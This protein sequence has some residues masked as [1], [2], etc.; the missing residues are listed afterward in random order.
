MLLLEAGQVGDVPDVSQVEVFERRV[1]QGLRFGRGRGRLGDERGAVGGKPER[2]VLER[3]VLQR[4][5]VVQ[6]VEDGAR[7]EVDGR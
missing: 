4:V 6:V 1:G 7:V 3:Q 2:E 5:G